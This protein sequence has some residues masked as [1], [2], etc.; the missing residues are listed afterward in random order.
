M[1]IEFTICCANSLLIHYLYPKFK[2]NSLSFSWI[3]F[4]FIFCFENSLS[5][6]YRYREFTLNSQSPWRIHCR[7]TIC[8]ANSLRK[9]TIRKTMIN[10]VRQHIEF[11]HIR[12]LIMVLI[13]MDVFKVWLTARLNS[14]A[15]ENHLVKTIWLETPWPIK[16]YTISSLPIF[17]PQIWF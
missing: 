10:L 7:F 17:N 14:T 13:L 8:S 1:H 4:E 2:L 12:P 6:Q 9:F 11:A 5:I 3:L 15:V 16:R